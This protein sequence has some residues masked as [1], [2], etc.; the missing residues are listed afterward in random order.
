MSNISDDSKN[1]SKFNSNPASSK[2]PL[3]FRQA[4]RQ[5]LK[6]SATALGVSL[7]PLPAVAIPGVQNAPTA[8]DSPAK[9]EGKPGAEV[10]A[11]GST[12]FFTPAQHKLVDELSETIIPKDSHS[13]GA[14]DAKVVDFIEQRVGDGGDAVQKELWRE[15]LRLIDSMSQHYTGKSFV[16]GSAED[17]V[18]VLTVLSDNDHMT[19]IPEVRFYRDLKHLTVL[20]YYTS[21]IGIHDEMEYKG[22]RYLQEF[23]GCD[24]PTPK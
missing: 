7:L 3:D 24:D 15:G 9:K 20:G 11:K 12:R 23:V 5:W 4:R 8:H 6:T 10:P 13:G 22:N 21:S 1:D 14:K 18:A 17:R 2:E 16:D 19:D